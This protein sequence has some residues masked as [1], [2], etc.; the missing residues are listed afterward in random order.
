MSVTSKPSASSSSQPT[1][2]RPPPASVASSFEEEIKVFFGE[3][4]EHLEFIELIRKKQEE[5]D[6]KKEK[7]PFQWRG[8]K[9]SIFPNLPKFGMKELKQ[10]LRLALQG[11]FNLS[12]REKKVIH[13]SF[14]FQY[15][16]YMSHILNFFL[17]VFAISSQP[18][19]TNSEQNPFTVTP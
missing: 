11:A 15:N 10:R 2:S 3:F 17:P 12:G 16:I 7:I 4:P 18:I 6:E 9:S 13:M 19:N 1:V 14:Q 8:Y 5:A